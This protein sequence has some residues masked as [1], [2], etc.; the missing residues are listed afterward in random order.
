MSLFLDN[1]KRSAS[2]LLAD[3]ALCRQFRHLGAEQREKTIHQTYAWA[4]NRILGYKQS[5]RVD[6]SKPCMDCGEPRSIYGTEIGR[7]FRCYSIN[8]E[9]FRDLWVED[10]FNIALDS[11]GFTCDSCT[12]IEG[13]TDDEARKVAVAILEND[14]A[15][16]PILCR[17]CA[18][19]YKRFCSR[20]YGKGSWRS[21]PSRDIEKMALAWFAQKVKNLAI[22]RVKAA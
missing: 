19:D 5:K 7:C 12:E 18:E 2:E 21:S 15:F 17:K 13:V 14:G 22:E 1:T 8:S 20:N 6:R 9:S 10:V 16:R 11:Y 4:T 3:L